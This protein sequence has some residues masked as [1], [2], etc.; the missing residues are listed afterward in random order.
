MRTKNTLPKV[1]TKYLPQP[2]NSY[3]VWVDIMGIST[4][5]VN[6]IQRAANFIM[7]FQSIVDQTYKQSVVPTTCELHVYPTMD[8]VYI[9][10]TTQ[11]ELIKLL[12]NIYFQVAQLFLWEAKKPQHPHKHQ[13]IIRGAIAYGPVIHGIKIGEKCCSS[14]TD[15]VKKKIVLGPPISQAYVSERLAPPFGIYIHESARAFAP[16]HTSKVLLG[17]YFYWSFHNIRHDMIYYTIGY[18]KYCKKYYN[19]LQLNPE[20]IEHYIELTKEYFSAVGT[21]H[22]VDMDENQ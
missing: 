5:L 14:L 22:Y 17:P 8:G 19:Y 11:A 3:V 18:F 15:D 10:S 9:T 16:K 13:F 7:K 6:N 21:K 12:N 1:N 20:K 2:T 4:L